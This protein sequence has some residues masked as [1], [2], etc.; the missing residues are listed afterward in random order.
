[1]TITLTIY[2]IGSEGLKYQL[3]CFEVDCHMYTCKTQH[4][5]PI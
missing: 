3:K 2:R 5:N 1:M 4:R